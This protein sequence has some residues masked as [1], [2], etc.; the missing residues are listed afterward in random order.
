[1]AVFMT[2]PR[3]EANRIILQLA[4][5]LLTCFNGCPSITRSLIFRCHCTSEV[6]MLSAVLSP[7][8][9]KG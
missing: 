8:S 1:M 2:L 7:G 5:Y 3:G 4:S 9:I 6:V